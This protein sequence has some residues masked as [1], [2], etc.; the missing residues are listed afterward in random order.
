MNVN[1][2]F[3]NVSSSYN[4]FL[5][6]VSE[7]VQVYAHLCMNFWWEPEANPSV[8]RLES[9]SLFLTQNLSQ[10]YGIHPFSYTG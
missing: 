1:N 3:N 4:H 9:F 2:F 5:C 10:G 8:I 7:Y 6:H